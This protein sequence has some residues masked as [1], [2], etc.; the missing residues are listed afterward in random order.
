MPPSPSLSLA[1]NE[2][3]QQ[4]PCPGVR[5]LATVYTEAASL[6]VT[7]RAAGKH[8]SHRLSPPP[9]GARRLDSLIDRAENNTCAGII[10]ASWSIGEAFHLRQ[11]AGSITRAFVRVRYGK[12]GW[13]GRRTG[14]AGTGGV[15][16]RGRHP[17]RRERADG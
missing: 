3:V 12:M 1:I 9:A 10:A 4:R 16:D 14:P 2:N 7:V 13:D 15:G 8:K 6:E 11:Q 17:I 5:A